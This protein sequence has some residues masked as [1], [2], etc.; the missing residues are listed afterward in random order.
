MIDISKIMRLTF[1]NHSP[2][3]PSAKGEIILELVQKISETL[4]RFLEN[5]KIYFLQI[6]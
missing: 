2:N 3:A 6:N 1:T 4:I 5:Q